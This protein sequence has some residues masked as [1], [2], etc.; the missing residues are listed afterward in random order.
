LK[1][2]TKQSTYRK[3]RW[4]FI[5]VLLGC[6]VYF[7]YRHFDRPNLRPEGLREL[8][9]GFVSHGIDISHHQGRIDWEEFT[10]SMDSTISFVYCKATEGIRFIDPSWKSN[11]SNLNSKQIANGAYHFFSPRI[12]AS[13]QA[14]HF[15]NN[16]TFL[17]GD[18]PPVLDAETEG[19]SDA[20]LISR[21]KEWLKSVETQTGMRP[22]IYTSYHFYKTK[23]RGKFEGY[24]FWIASYNKNESRLKDDCIIHWQYSDR[25]KLPGINENVDLN[26]SKLDF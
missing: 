3:F 8:P 14:D 1:R 6:T 17:P 25:G 16:Y 5:V 21:M 13:L 10:R 23:F 19:G 20:Q 24:E 2:R 9:E 4:T 26:F 18:L 15:L 11:R 22:V 7:T 12:N